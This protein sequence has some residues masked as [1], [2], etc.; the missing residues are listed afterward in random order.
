MLHQRGALRP[1]TK[2]RK[3][4]VGYIHICSITYNMWGGRLKPSTF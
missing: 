4:K 2:V 1:A 3:K